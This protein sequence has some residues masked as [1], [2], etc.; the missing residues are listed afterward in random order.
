MNEKDWELLQ[1]L[2][3][4]KNITKAAE[5]LFI[6]QPALTYRLRSLE[7]EFG[8]EIAKRGTKRLQFTSEGE[9]LVEYSRKMLNELAK[10]KD[11]LLNMAGNIQGHLRIGVS[12]HFAHYRLPTILKDFLAVYPNVQVNVTTGWSTKISQ[13]LEKKEVH[14][15]II[16]G[17]YEW[18]EQSILLNEENVCLISK[19]KIHMGD[20]PSI[21]RISYKTDPIFDNMIK[22][23][24]NHHF[25][26]PPMVTMEVDRIETCKEMV[27][28][29]LG[30]AIIPQI[31]LRPHDQLYNRILAIDNHPLLRKTWLIY[32]NSALDLSVV[33]AFVQ[34]VTTQLR[35]Q[36]HSL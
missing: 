8:V 20:L 18:K 13:K 21:G 5:K 27:R 23:W 29:G 14:I 3:E 11:Q 17:S 28:N 6:S 26:Q 4:M 19:N 22:D 30:Y 24:W 25:S 32:S 35:Q 34:F 33:K 10:T 9:Y 1:T 15:G 36:A 12:S 7:N 16:R 31:S 2:Y